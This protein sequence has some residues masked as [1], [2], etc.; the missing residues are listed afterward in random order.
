VFLGCSKR[1]CPARRAMRASPLNYV[2]ESDAPMLMA[3][4]STD[5]IPLSWVQ[6]MADALADVGVE[7]DLVILPGGGHSTT[8]APA[9]SQDTVAFLDAYLKAE[10][11]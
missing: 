8:L 2:D 11:T 3:E 5:L 10:G 6:P 7:H 1:N 9:V 4:A